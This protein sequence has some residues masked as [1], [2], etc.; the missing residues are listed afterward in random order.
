VVDSVKLEFVDVVPVVEEL[1]PDVDAAT[2]VAPVDVDVDVDVVTA[3]GGY[4]LMQDAS[5]TV[6]TAT[7]WKH[8]VDVGDVSILTVNEKVSP[9]YVT[10]WYWLNNTEQNA[11]GVVTGI[12]DQ[13]PGTIP[14]HVVNRLSH[15]D[16]HNDKVIALLARSPVRYVAEPDAQGAHI[17]EESV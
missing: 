15:V 3:A 2:V 5:L 12:R 8:V 16:A 6:S 10:V 1:R 11:P 7:L 9:L 14:L 13:F 17:R 4:L